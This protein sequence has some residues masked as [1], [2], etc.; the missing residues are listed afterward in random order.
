M[1]P[2]SGRAHL[3]HGT[4]VVQGSTHG[5]DDPI[6]PDNV[7]AV[8]VHAVGGLGTEPDRKR[9]RQG[10]RQSAKLPKRQRE[11]RTAARPRGDTAAPPPSGGTVAPDRR[12]ADTG[13]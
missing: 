8:C 13:S 9:V 12:I 6:D 2:L 3:R 5:A 11:R 7:E 1:V 4:T 10:P